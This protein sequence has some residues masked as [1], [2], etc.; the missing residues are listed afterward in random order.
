MV[1]TLCLVSRVNS[2]S[3]RLLGPSAVI[4]EFPRVRIRST[5]TVYSSYE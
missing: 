1:L 5:P 4:L 2:L 3:M